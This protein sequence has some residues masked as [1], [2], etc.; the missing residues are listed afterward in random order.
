[1]HRNKHKEEAKIGIKRIRPQMRDQENSPEEDINEMEVSNLSDTEFR[2]MIIRILNSMT[3][4]IET[5]KKD[6]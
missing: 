2:V 1:M 5:I 3:K 4:N 6:Q